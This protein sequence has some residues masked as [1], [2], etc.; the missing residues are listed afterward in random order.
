MESS[1]LEQIGRK[2]REIRLHRSMTQEQLAN[3]CHTDPSYIRKVESG[4]VNIS[5]KR[6]KVLCD[7]LSVSLSAFFKDIDTRK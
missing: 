2:I 1:L 7:S 5:V 6:L 3:L 4:N